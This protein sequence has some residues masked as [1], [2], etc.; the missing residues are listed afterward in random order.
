MGFR[1][2]PGFHFQSDLEITAV[3]SLPL[4]RPVLLDAQIQAAQSAQNNQRQ[5]NQ[6]DVEHYGH[7]LL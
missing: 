1:I 4:N 6:P 2:F 5:W 7:E 3:F